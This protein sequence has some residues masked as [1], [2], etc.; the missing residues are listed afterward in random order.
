[1]QLMAVF[2]SIQ[3]FRKGF[4]F[5]ITFYFFIYNLPSFQKDFRQFIGHAHHIQDHKNSL[6]GS[7]PLMSFVLA[8][9]WVFKELNDY[10]LNLHMPEHKNAED[11]RSLS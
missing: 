6:K 10:V 1:M 4:L 2:Q 8:I 11:N 9:L 7:A 5:Q 3:T